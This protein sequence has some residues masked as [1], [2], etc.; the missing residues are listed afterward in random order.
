VFVKGLAGLFW[1]M[2]TSVLGYYLAPY[3]V[4]TLRSV[5]RKG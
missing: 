2:T 4:T 5:L 3:V 1:G